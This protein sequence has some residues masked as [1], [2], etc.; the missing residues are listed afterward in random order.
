MR[1]PFLKSCMQYGECLA[2]MREKLV[3]CSGDGVCWGG[4]PGVKEHSV[5]TRHLP[6]ILGRPFDI[7]YKQTK[8][9]TKPKTTTTNICSVLGMSVCICASM[10]IEIRC[11]HQEFSST[12]SPFY[13]LRQGLSLNLELPDGL[14]WLAHKPQLSP[15]LY[16]PRAGLGGHTWLLHTCW[17]SELSDSWW[18]PSQLSHSPVSDT[19][20]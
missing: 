14:G 9:Q 17:R 11:Q 2:Q 12:T 3:L 19:P 16:H 5:L 13:L 15:G 4:A 10:N 6:E 1:Q 20:E 18:T 8:N 7:L